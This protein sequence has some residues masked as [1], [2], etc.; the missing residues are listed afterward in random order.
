MAQIG[1]EK[2]ARAL[3]QNDGLLSYAARDLHCTIGTLYA[4]LGRYQEL[5]D[6]VDYAREELIDIAER[7]LREALE[8]EHASPWAIK[9]TLSRL[10]KHRGYSAIDHTGNTGNNG[11]A[12]L[13]GKG[14]SG[15]LKEIEHAS[16]NG[17]SRN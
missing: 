4:Y 11:N 17:H 2:V 7:R 6:L 3:V 15:L 12:E 16:K 13:D 10:G 1:K 5:R 14:L 9:F 8:G